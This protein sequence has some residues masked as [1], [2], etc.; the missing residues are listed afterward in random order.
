M[1]AALKA[2]GDKAETI[3]YRGVGHIGIIASLL[4]PLRFTRPLRDDMLRFIGA[5]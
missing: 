5:R 2:H 3:S 1:A 4:P